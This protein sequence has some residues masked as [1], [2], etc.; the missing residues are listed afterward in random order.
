MSKTS[1][2]ARGKAGQGMP[3]TPGPIKPETSET[4][5]AGLVRPETMDPKF[6]AM[7]PVWLAAVARDLEAA[8]KE[9][10]HLEEADRY[11]A[12]AASVPDEPAIRAAIV[13]ARRR[14]L[15]DPIFP[16]SEASRAKAA[17]HR[18]EAAVAGDLRG[19]T[20]AA[21]AAAERGAVAEVRAALGS[22]YGMFV[23]AVASRLALTLMALRH[24]RTWMDQL[25]RDGCPVRF[26]GPPRELLSLL[27]DAGP[28]RKWAV[29]LRDQGS[30][31][32]ATLV[33]ILDGPIT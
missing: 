7:A 6:Q 9:A 24:F 31:E 27:D 22:D 26:E 18:R 1:I 13:D 11:D 20:R 19:D 23:Q 17:Y 3:E 12:E 15:E 29:K 28:L 32:A 21:R 10:H 33:A 4:E 2:P 30:I 14:G 8:E 5:T 25:E 16:T